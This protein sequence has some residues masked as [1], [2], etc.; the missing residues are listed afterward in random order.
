MILIE[1]IPEA[2]MF[3]NFSLVTSSSATNAVRTLST[4]TKPT[5]GR[6]ELGGVKLKDRSTIRLIVLLKA[7]TTWIA[8]A[9]NRR[10]TAFRDYYATNNT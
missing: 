4:G 2:E 5:M 6:A 1:D 10:L 9:A 8:A 7:V 3:E